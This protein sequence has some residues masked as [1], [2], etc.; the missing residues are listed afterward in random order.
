MRTFG[1]SLPNS[2]CQIFR[3]GPISVEPLPFRLA[4]RLAASMLGGRLGSG[5]ADAVGEVLSP[6]WEIAGLDDVSLS[7]VALP[8][9]SINAVRNSM[10]INRKKRWLFVA[11]F[12]ENI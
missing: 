12:S 1:A 8:Q 6:D 10:L 9:G 2:C 7:A 4:L 11:K 3:A 5:V